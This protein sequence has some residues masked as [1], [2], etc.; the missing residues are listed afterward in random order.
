MNLGE[1]FSFDEMCKTSAP[2]IN[3]PSDWQ[4]VGMTRLVCL[5]LDPLRRKVGRINVTSGFRSVSVNMFVRGAS[6]SA[7]KKGL[8]VDIVH[9]ELS[10][11]DLVAEIIELG[12][13]FDK[14]IM[15][16]DKKGNQWLHWQIASAGNDNKCLL[17]VAE[18]VNGNMVYT[19]I[20]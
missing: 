20:D 19:L 12:L 10:P 8:A 2:Y 13:P 3:T 5:C 11:H 16:E 1:Y 9:D 4:L 17:F 15:E 7:H 18:P 14:L 6:S